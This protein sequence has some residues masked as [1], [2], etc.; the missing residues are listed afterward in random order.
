MPLTTLHAIETAN[1]LPP[2]SAIAELV[3]I[4]FSTIHLSL[5]FIHPARFRSQFRHGSHSSRPSLALVYAMLAITTPYSASSSL[6]QTST[7]YYS[8]ARAKM[9]DDLTADS[10]MGYGNSRSPAVG[11]L[12]LDTVQCGVLLA[13]IEFGEADHQQAFMTAVRGVV[14]LTF[15]A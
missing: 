13:I 3:D 2:M 10:K 1:D 15:Y 8:R 7:Y 6:R 12:T 4:Y 9:E 5:P 14:Y 11:S